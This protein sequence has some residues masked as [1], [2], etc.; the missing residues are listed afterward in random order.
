MCIL[1]IMHGQNSSKYKLIIA[2]NRDE[3]Y[4][5]PTKDAMFHGRNNHVLCGQD[6]QHGDG[7]TWLGINKSG[8]F[9]A[10]TNYLVPAV[11]LTK[12]SRGRIVKNYLEDDSSP[13]DYCK[14][15]SHENYRGFNIIAGDFKSNPAKAYY[16]SNM[17]DAKVQ[18]LKTVVNVLAS[19]TLNRGW[20][21]VEHGKKIFEEILG[22]INNLTENEIV[23][24][25]FSK[26]LSDKTELYP[27]PLVVKQSQDRLETNILRKYCS[28]QISDLPIYGT[29]V[30]TVILVD[31]DN[32]VTY[33]ERVLK[34]DNIKNGL[35]DEWYP[36]VSHMFSI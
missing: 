31:Y 6:L 28:I 26:L 36:H 1:F 27:D 12:Q 11:D 35:Y 30:Q 34:L 17:E 29:G 25:L 4:E 18:E 9:A 22:E 16:Y 23:E 13:F 8:K 21:K 2:S 15:L 3:Y 7:G 5:R 33:S 24:L 19:T 14:D 32:Q 20:R 10:L